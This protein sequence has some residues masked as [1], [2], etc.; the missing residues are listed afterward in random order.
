MYDFLVNYIEAMDSLQLF[1][2]VPFRELLVPMVLVFC[3]AGLF[4]GI[5]GSWTSIRKFM[6]V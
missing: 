2:F 4:V 3:G 6:N 5:I 1:N